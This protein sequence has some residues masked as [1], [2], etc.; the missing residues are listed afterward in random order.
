MKSSA[1]SWSVS[2]SQ[3]Q[4]ALEADVEYT[5]VFRARGDRERNAWVWLQERGEPYEGPL[6]RRFDLTTEWQE[7]EFHG[8]SPLSDPDA[9]LVFAVGEASGSIWLDEVRLYAGGL[10]VWRRDYENATDENC[11]LD[12]GPM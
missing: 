9:N 5:L 10:D 6:S 1:P 3:A 4:L 8:L 7:Y 2:F 12:R 11:A